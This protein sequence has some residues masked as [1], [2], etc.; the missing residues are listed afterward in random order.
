MNPDPNSI[1]RENVKYLK[2]G[3]FLVP[4]FI[5]AHVHA[6]QVPNIGLGYDKSLLDWLDAYTFPLEKQYADTKFAR[7]VFNAVVVCKY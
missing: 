5:D 6:V 1:N 2:K 7:R 4:G 3:Q